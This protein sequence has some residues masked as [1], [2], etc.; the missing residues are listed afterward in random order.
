[1]TTEGNSTVLPCGHEVFDAAQTHYCEYVSL[2][3]LLALLQP[4]ATGRAREFLHHDELQFVGVHQIAEL[5]FAI[6]LHTLRAA[7]AAITEMPNGDSKRA[8]TLLDRLIVWTR[9]HAAA[10]KVFHTMHPDDFGKFRDALAPASGAESIA[11]R[12]IEILSGIRPDSPYAENC[13]HAYTF[14][15][16]LDRAPGPD[17]N[18]PKTRWWIPA[19]DDLAREVSL[20]AAFDSALVRAGVSL[21]IIYPLYAT[22]ADPRW[23]WLR[24]LADRVHVYDKAFVDYRYAHIA[25][26]QAIIGKKP[27]TG[28]TSGV[29]Y[30]LA[31]AATARFHPE[32]WRFKAARQPSRA[33]GAWGV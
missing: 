10:V 19:F 8:C 28:H 16:F 20:A 1:M 32:L 14:R 29:P 6:H 22:D 5:G 13:G 3:R 33:D 27:G 21:A 15:E 26:A 17:P 30:L 18:E 4:N 23:L 11:F 24:E 7:I 2:E 31:V 9:Q 25:V 12:M